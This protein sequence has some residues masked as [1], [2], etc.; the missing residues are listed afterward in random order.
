MRRSLQIAVIAVV[1]FLALGAVAFV[2]AN[3]QGR[4]T[5][6][7]SELQTGMWS[8]RMDYAWDNVTL[9]DN[10]TGPCHMRGMRGMPQMGGNELWLSEG[11]LENA[12]LST[13]Q[14]T[15]VSEVR[16]MLILDTGS[17]EVRILLPQEWTVGTEVVDR[18]S[19]FNGTF[20]SPGQSVTVKVLENTLFSN[21][22]FSINTMMAYEA[23]NATSMH[24]YAV[25]PFNIQSNS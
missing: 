3:S 10:V 13:V 9:P 25:L 15:V 7:A 23:I 1:A 5:Y 18:V 4:N 14:G 2:Y 16:R 6:S 12:T 20:A 24:A 22:S 17:G 21:D 8:P 19:L 11:L